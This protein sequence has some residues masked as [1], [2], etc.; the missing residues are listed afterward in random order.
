M[1]LH[2]HSRGLKQKKSPC[3]FRHK[4]PFWWYVRGAL[5]VEK[6]GLSHLKNV[7]VTQGRALLTLFRHLAK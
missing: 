1:Y 2:T 7:D 5:V 3:V 6:S 4:C